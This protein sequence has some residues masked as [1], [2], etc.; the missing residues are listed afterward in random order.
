MEVIKRRPDLDVE[1]FQDHWLNNHGPIVARLPGLRRYVQSHTRLGGYRRGDVAYDGIAELWFDDKEALAAITATEE[2]AAAKQDEANF[3]DTGNLIELVVDDHVI[4]DGP[5]PHGGIK[6]IE[7]VK[8][9]SDL[10]PQEA[11]R[12][13]RE[14]HG[15]IAASIPTMARYVQSHT[16]MGAYDRPEPPP[17]D[18]V[19]LTWWDGIEAMR[20]SATSPELAATRADEPNFLGVTPDVILTTEHV[21]VG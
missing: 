21:I 15:P 11:H 13:W 9:S 19:A 1:A 6:N 12:Y 7:F 3:I 8:L 2:F 18:G 16:R 10:S 20:A 5:F 4:K 17:F 14:V